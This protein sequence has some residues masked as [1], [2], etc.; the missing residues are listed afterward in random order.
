MKNLQVYLELVRIALEM[1]S[2]GMLEAEEELG[3]LQSEI[4]DDEVVVDEDE[5]NEVDDIEANIQS[6][7]GDI[8]SILE[9]VQDFLDKL[10]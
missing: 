2:S 3:N 9:Q 8:G 5:G 7:N 10:K 4:R 1:A 6:L